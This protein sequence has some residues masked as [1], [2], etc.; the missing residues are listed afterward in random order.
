[1]PPME[2]GPARAVD[3]VG[4]TNS[5]PTPPARNKQVEQDRAS[6][7]LP[8]HAQLAWPAVGE[9]RSH[10]QLDRKYDNPNGSEDSR[11]TRY[12]PVPHRSQGDRCRVGCF[13]S[14]TCNLSRRMELHTASESEKKIVSLF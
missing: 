4:N 8:H 7:V 10:R 12:G 5:R 9:S 14:Q 1:M 6:H 11:R 2:S 13:E 3:Q